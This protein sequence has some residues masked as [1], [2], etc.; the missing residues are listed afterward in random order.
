MLQPS[1]QGRIDYV[2]VRLTMDN[3]ELVAV[4][5][6]GKSGLIRTMLEADGL[7]EIPVNDEGIE[8]GASVPVLPMAWPVRPEPGPSGDLA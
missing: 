5:V 7:V 2:R 8:K 1:A 6:L 4:P 3:G